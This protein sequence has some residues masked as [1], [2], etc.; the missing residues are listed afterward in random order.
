[1]HFLSYFILPVV[2]LLF[3]GCA[4]PDRTP[5]GDTPTSGPLAAPEQVT[6]S[7]VAPA[8]PHDGDNQSSATA[9][10]SA[11]AMFHYICPNRCKGGGS[12]EQGKC[13]VCNTDLIHN[14][15]YHNQPQPQSATPAQPA[16][17]QVKDLSVTP[18]SPPAEPAQ[19]ARGV[20]HYI[21]PNGC[22]GGGGQAIACATCGTQMV[23]NQAY[24][25]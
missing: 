9:D 16:Q 22:P 5:E 24:H 11:M 3:I 20:W 19:N 7:D 25:E 17:P 2:F 10:A 21:C 23:H 4:S 6:P 15:A 12:Q 14:D 18:P 1:M 13:P 8:K